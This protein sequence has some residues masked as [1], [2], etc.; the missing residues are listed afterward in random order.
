MASF[1][2]TCSH[3]LKGTCKYGDKCKMSHAAAPQVS[4]VKHRSAAGGDGM[5]QKRQVEQKA[6]RSSTTKEKTTQANGTV[7]TRETIVREFVGN[8]EERGHRKIPHSLPSAKN[9]AT[10]F[11]LDKDDLICHHFLNGTCKYGDK[12]K[13]SHAR[14][15]IFKTSPPK[16]VFSGS[17]G[18]GRHS[19][20][21]PI[22]LKSTLARNVV[23]LLASSPGRCLSGADFP[24]AYAARYNVKL[25][26]QGGQ[27]KDLLS[28]LEAGGSCNLEKRQMPNG[29]TLLYVDG[30]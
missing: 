5:L 29:T 25:D 15:D 23:L 17:D 30:G 14:P 12:C 28:R 10:A 3:F 13:K 18:V 1:K 24:A 27:L 8:F 11:D 9:P 22:S 2:P 7:I 21:G 16:F 4:V 20:Q 19:A 6:I 26:Y